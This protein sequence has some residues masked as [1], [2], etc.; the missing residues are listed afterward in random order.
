MVLK[1]SESM[2]SSEIILKGGVGQMNFDNKDF[3]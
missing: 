3:K 1:S 2:K